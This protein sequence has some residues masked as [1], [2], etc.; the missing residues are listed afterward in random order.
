MLT[1]ESRTTD[2]LV[3]GAGVAAL[4]AAVAAREAG[5]EVSLCCKGIAGL[6]AN[7]I[8]STADISAY[9]PPLGPDDSEETFASDTIQTGGSIADEQL[10]RI[11][12]ERSGAALL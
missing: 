9:T 7:T 5:A 2:V 10:V 6:T 8:G 11:L 1:I 4:R 12:A 3:I